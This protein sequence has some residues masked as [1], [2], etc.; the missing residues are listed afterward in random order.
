MF[1]GL[2]TG[3]VG[4][5]VSVITSPPHEPLRAAVVRR[6]AAFLHVAVT[7]VS[8]AQITCP[9]PVSTAQTLASVDKDKPQR[10][11]T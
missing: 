8:G 2:I 4:S 6:R 11:L 5:S 10:C 1:P 3:L 7:W 9:G